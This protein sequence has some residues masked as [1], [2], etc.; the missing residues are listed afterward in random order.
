MSN[1]IFSNAVTSF[2]CWPI[3]TNYMF[4]I[5]LFLSVA[6]V[7][8]PALYTY[9]DDVKKK[10]KE[11]LTDSTITLSKERASLFC[12]LLGAL[13]FFYNSCDA[14]NQAIKNAEQARVSD[15]IAN[16]K[17]SLYTDL[18]TK[19]IDTAKG[20]TE[21]NISLTTTTTDLIRTATNL[22][23]ASQQLINRV[24]QRT[25]TGLNKIVDITSQS[26]QERQAQ[27]Y[28][29]ELEAGT[30]MQNT[31]IF[32][33]QN[34]LSFGVGDDSLQLI[35]KL[36]TFNTKFSSVYPNHL[37]K[38]DKRIDK[39]WKECI[40][41]IEASKML[42]KQGFGNSANPN[43][44]SDQRMTA[45]NLSNGLGEY[46]SQIYLRVLNISSYIEER[47]R[48]D[49]SLGNIREMYDYTVPSY[50]PEDSIRR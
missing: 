50:V 4:Y 42:V 20:L 28:T 19:K 47:L 10:K 41:Y 35:R 45:L 21:R 27:F 12:G 24:D 6:L 17:D 29:K 36:D 31:I 40:F 33:N 34:I 44:I 15:S 9:L 13:I 48:K 32:F 14:N 1:L 25:Q 46:R 26:P 37:T 7:I 22:E 30:Q 5:L 11:R 43:P 2:I 39:L 16:A 3:D 38:I 23:H 8:V 49:K 18:V